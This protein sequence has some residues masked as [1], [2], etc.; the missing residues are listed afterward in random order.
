MKLPFSKLPDGDFFVAGQ[1]D[2]FLRIGDF[3][4]ATPLLPQGTLCEKRAKCQSCFW[5]NFYPNFFEI[6]DKRSEDNILPGQ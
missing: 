1:R 4:H 5:P 2:T 6:E 3:E